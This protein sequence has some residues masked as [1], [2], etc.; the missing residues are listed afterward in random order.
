MGRKKW[1]LLILGVFFLIRIAAAFFINAGIIPGDDSTQY[2]NY[3]CVILEDFKWLYSPNFEGSSREPGYPIFLAM[4][5]FLFGKE[6]FL[7]AYILQAFVSVLTVFIIYRLVLKIFDERVTLVAL[8]WSGLYGF[9]LWFSAHI[10][11]ETLICFLLIAFFYL[12]YTC[13]ISSTHRKSNIFAISLSFFLLAHTDARYLYLLPCIVILFIIYHRFS[14]GIKNFIIFSLLVIIFSVPWAVRNYVAYKDFVLISTFY[15]DPESNV[16]KEFMGNSAR[17]SKIIKWDLNNE[18]V[19]TIYNPEYPTEEERELV[20]EGLNPHNRSKEEINA[21]KKNIYPAAT[22]WGR[23]WYNLREF[24]RPFTLRGFYT[25]FPA[26]K[27]RIWSLRHNLISIISYGALLPFVLIGIIKMIGDKNRNLWFFIL[28][29]FFH[30][31]AHNVVWGNYRYRIPMD[32]FLIIL[33]AYG[34]TL[35]YRFI[36]TGFKKNKIAY[37]NGGT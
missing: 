3:A 7:A 26:C 16:I 5:Y 8:I 15:A 11:R 20:K 22:F 10:L 1:I 36:R 12:L 4:V 21:I 32:S 18:R 35:A 27:F 30:T 23:R 31:L 14:I 17:Y 24:W 13:L 33:G 37:D 9:Y 19:G 25:P 2:N 29:L 34:I 6:N 28:P